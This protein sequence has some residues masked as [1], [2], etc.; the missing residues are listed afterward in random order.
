MKSFL[1]ILLACWL[2]SFFLTASPVDEAVG[3][4]ENATEK[5]GETN[6]LEDVQQIE[7][8]TKERLNHLGIDTQQLPYEQ[9][10]KLR[11]AAEKFANA[12]H[13]KSMELG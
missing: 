13:T 7:L 10:E 4:M 6:C 11:N 3:T 5:I 9:Q 1:T 2:F 12:V 8:L